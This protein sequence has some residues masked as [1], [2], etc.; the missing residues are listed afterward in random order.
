MSLSGRK[1]VFFNIEKKRNIVHKIASVGSN[2]YN[3]IA[4]PNFVK[5]KNNTI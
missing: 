4:K 3:F 2:A 1:C 5:L